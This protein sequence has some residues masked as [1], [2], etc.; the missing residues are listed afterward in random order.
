M[1]VTR[2]LVEYSQSSALTSGAFQSKELDQ[3]EL[4]G[5]REAIPFHRW[6]ELAVKLVG[7]SDLPRLHQA[8]RQTQGELTLLTSPHLH[9]VTAYSIESKFATV[10][11]RWES[12][13]AMLR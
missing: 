11:H 2:I 6:P 13:S 3:F 7:D 8:N 9:P 4:Y 1:E 12:S 10:H 5:C